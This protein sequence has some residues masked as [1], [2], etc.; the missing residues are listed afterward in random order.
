VG[1]I[2]VAK[3]KVI[4]HTAPV[5]EVSD[6]EQVKVASD[7]HHIEVAD[8]DGV[9]D[10]M[11]VTLDGPLSEV[12]TKALNLVYAKEG[13]DSMYELSESP[14]DDHEGLYVYCCDGEM[15]GS[16]LN[17]GM[18]Q[19]NRAVES[20]RNVIM[21]IDGSRGINEKSGLME[22]YAST[23]GIRTVMSQRTAIESIQ[24]MVMRV[25]K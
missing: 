10:G 12:Y 21:V 15:T 19:I 7:G 17:E 5:A 8:D 25:L 23:K 3:R 18:A 20:Y 4:E 24:A 16:D 11:S 14:D 6:D 22:R 9:Q 2:N 1:I 13:V